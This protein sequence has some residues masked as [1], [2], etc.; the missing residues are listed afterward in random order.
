MHHC[1]RRAII[2]LVLGTAL[3]IPSLA[4]TPADETITIVASPVIEANRVDNQGSLSTVVTETERSAGSGTKKSSA[5]ALRQPST[6]AC[7]AR[8]SRR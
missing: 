1:H 2:P 6:A 7:T 5:P 4:A 3:S 8:V